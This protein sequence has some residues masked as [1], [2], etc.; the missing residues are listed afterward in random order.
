MGETRERCD[1]L[2][3]LRGLCA[4]AV[5]TLHYCEAYR[6]WGLVPHSHLAVEY[7]LTLTGFTFVL[8]YDGRWASGELT[9]GRFLWRR[10]VR[11]WPVVLIGSVIGL[12]YCFTRTVDFAG[13]SRDPL[14]LIGLFLY[15]LTMLPHSGPFVAPM[16]PQTWTLLYI[17]YVNLLYAFLLRHMKTWMLGLAA[18]AAAGYSFWV[19]SAYFSYEAGWALKDRH[20]TI[21]CAR[22]LFPTLAGMFLARLRWKL[23]FRGA[24]VVAALLLGFL[25]FSPTFGLRGV[26]AGRCEFLMVLVGMPLVL[27]CGCG[28]KVPEGR[29]AAFCRFLG[30]F[31]FPLYVTHWPFRVSLGTWVADHPNATFAQNLST[32]VAYVA[33]ALALACLAMKAADVLADLLTGKR[34]HRTKVST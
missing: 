11:L 23:S 20:V 3:G 8:A 26:A 7:F 22:V 31:S 25:L 30:K 14:G 16:Q 9:L 13:A 19:A 29:F 27:L 33:G 28:G 18:V 24:G 34:R 32:V 15:A 6:V 4:V 21:A 12:L 5:L 2:D 1:V 17:I 10:F